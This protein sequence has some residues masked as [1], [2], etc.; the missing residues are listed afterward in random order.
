MKK[1]TVKIKNISLDREVTMV[2]FGSLDRGNVSDLT[3]WG[4]FS[5]TGSIEFFDTNMGTAESFETVM[6]YAPNATVCIYYNSGN[7][8]KLL[9]T[10]LIDDYEIN[11]ETKKVSLMARAKHRRILRILPKV[12]LRYLERNLFRRNKNHKFSRR[13][14]AEYKH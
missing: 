5:N 14:D 10:F 3:N 8:E 9:A 1:L 11:Y 6:S 2:S 4:C 13:I 12:S 7:I